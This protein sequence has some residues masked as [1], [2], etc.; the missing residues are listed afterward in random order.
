MKCKSGNVLLS[1][2]REYDMLSMHLLFVGDLGKVRNCAFITAPLRGMKTRCCFRS[3]R[4]TNAGVVDFR[5][6]LIMR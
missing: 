1:Y 6:I 2:S 4:K 3:A 5:R